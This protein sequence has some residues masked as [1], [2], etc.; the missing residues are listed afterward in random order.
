MEEYIKQHTHT[1]TN[2]PQVYL[3]L[4]SINFFQNNIL[5]VA[6]P[7]KVSFLSSITAVIMFLPVVI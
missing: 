1:H 4:L 3:E 5:E 6:T 2:T 7:D